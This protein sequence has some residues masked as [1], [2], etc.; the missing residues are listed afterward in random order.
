VKESEHLEHL[1]S[2]IQELHAMQSSRSL[3][4]SQDLSKSSPKGGGSLELIQR[5]QEISLKPKISPELRNS[6]NRTSQVNNKPVFKEITSDADLSMEDIINTDGSKPSIKIHESDISNSESRYFKKFGLSPPIT[7]NTQYYVGPDE[8]EKSSV[9]RP[10]MGTESSKTSTT[11]K[12]NCC[13][14]I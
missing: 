9:N 13:T 11:K 8:D 12:N 2:D 3:G 14:I 10:L 6:G 1:D 7:N 5:S 4:G